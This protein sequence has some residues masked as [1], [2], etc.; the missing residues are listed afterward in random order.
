MCAGFASRQQVK[1]ST[2][3]ALSLL[4]YNQPMVSVLLCHSG[5]RS[6][7]G[8]NPCQSCADGDQGRNTQTSFVW[9]QHRLHKL[10]SPPMLQVSWVLSLPLAQLA[11]N[12]PRH[13]V[14][15]TEAVFPLM[16]VKVFMYRQPMS[17][18]GLGE[19]QARQCS[20]TLWPMS[21]SKSDSVHCLQ[22]VLLRVS[23]QD[24][25]P[26]SKLMSC[27]DRLV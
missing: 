12:A 17:I 23:G 18:I 9:Y 15:C 14:Q 16:L 10:L 4:L 2:C 5:R 22:G 6:W 11:H 19:V 25:P 24:T 8:R 3:R 27:M 13:Y 7:H 20:E 1:V 26:N 21:D